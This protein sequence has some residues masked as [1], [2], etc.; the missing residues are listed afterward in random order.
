[1]RGGLLTVADASSPEAG[2]RQLLG[3]EGVRP[4]QPVAT[5]VNGVPAVASHFQTQTERGAIGGLAAFFG[6]GGRTYEVVG[7]APTE[8][9]AN[10]DATMRRTLGS[11]APLAHSALLGVQP[12][13]AEVVRLVARMTPAEL[14][15][16]NASTV[17]PCT[18]AI[19]NQVP[20]PGTPLPAGALAKV[21]TGRTR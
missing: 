5:T 1:M 14:G 4:G 15:R 20:G 19:L 8:R 6:Y 7:Y 10:F 16:R 13:R 17:A 9:V 11:F 2:A 12:A 18:L 3:R 21:V